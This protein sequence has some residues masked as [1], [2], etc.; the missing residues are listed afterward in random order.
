MVIVV[1]GT[2]DR[3]SLAQ[4]FLLDSWEGQYFLDASIRTVAYESVNS[5]VP[6]FFG[7][8]I[9]ICGYIASYIKVQIY[10][11]LKPTCGLH[12]EKKCCLC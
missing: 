9:L 6:Y 7:L 5:F 1:R 4:E 2:A 11:Y 8:G 3:M 10:S 12:I